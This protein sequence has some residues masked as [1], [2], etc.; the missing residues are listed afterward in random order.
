M[1]GLSPLGMITV[2]VTI[3]WWVCGQRY[4]WQIWVWVTGYVVINMSF[5][6]EYENVEQGA[7]EM[8]TKENQSIR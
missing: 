7:L 6:L 1:E 3:V 5:A 2:Y 4:E 8:D